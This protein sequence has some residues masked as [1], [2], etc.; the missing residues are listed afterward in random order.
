MVNDH[1]EI[2]DNSFYIIDSSFNNGDIE[3]GVIDEIKFPSYYT[4][5]MLQ[6][7]KEMIKDAI[8]RYDGYGSR[9]RSQIKNNSK[10]SGTLLSKSQRSTQSIRG[11]SS[12]NEGRIS[13]EDGNNGGIKYSR[14]KVS[15]VQASKDY[16]QHMQD[17][18]LVFK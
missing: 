7:A 11:E 3:L 12:N 6:K 17:K 14:I 1:V 4:E 18:I 13:K 9:L 5:K 16:A 8:R 2:L 10:S 15:G